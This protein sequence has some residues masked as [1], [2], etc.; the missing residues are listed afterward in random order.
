MDIRKRGQ[1][2]VC[3][4]CGAEFML[5][6]TMWRHFYAELE[7]FRQQGRDYQAR[8][9][10]SRLERRRELGIPDRAGRGSGR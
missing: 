1:F 10:Q 3:T 4:I 7:G 6:G 5:A 2:H 8:F 9:E